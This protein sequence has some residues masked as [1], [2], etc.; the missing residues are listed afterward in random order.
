M[1]PIA[2]ESK[3]RG[4][5]IGVAYTWVSGNGYGKVQN[6]FFSFSTYTYNEMT[7]LVLDVFYSC[8]R[9]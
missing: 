4:P 2:R 3:E 8:F 1:K 5:R 6:V 7:A 9:K